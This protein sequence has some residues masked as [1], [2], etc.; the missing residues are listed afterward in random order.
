MAKRLVTLALTI[1]AVFALAPIQT[2]AQDQTTYSIEEYDFGPWTNKTSTNQTLSNTTG[3]STSGSTVYLLENFLDKD[4]VNH[5]LS[6]RFAFSK[7]TA[8]ATE[9]PYGW[10]KFVGYATSNSV[11]NELVTCGLQLNGKNGLISIQDLHKGD[12]ITIVHSLSQTTDTSADGLYIITTN[13]T[14]D[15]NGTPTAST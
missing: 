4:D 5:L 9:N 11:T 8:N 6:G 3:T 1:V 2:Y 15:K 10:T 7:I 14:Y 13:A 12:I